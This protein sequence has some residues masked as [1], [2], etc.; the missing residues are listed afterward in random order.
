MNNFILC[1]YTFLILGY[2]FWVTL[3][4]F[5]RFGTLGGGFSFL[6]CNGRVIFEQGIGRV[7]CLDPFLLNPPFYNLTSDQVSFKSFRLPQDVGL[8]G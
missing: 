2:K 4:C 3:K 6:S 8:D 5:T 7:G 1:I